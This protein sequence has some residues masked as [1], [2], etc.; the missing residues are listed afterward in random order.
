MVVSKK[1]LFFVHVLKANDEKSRILSRNRI[2]IRKSLVQIC[3]PGSGSASAPKCHGSTI[4]RYR[5]LLVR[6]HLRDL[7]PLP[8]HIL[9]F[10]YFFNI[11]ICIFFSSSF[12][13]PQASRS[14]LEKEIEEH[15]E[16]FEQELIEIEKRLKD[17]C[18]LLN[19][20]FSIFLSVVYR[21]VQKV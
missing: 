12:S 18:V 14:K 20:F 21:N 11:C 15:K 13:F 10:S 2:Q 16:M 17:R 8:V 6:D 5:D 19:L 4:L 1:N 7:R 3:G 9:I